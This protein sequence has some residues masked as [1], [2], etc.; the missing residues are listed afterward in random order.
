MVGTAGGGGGGGGGVGE[1]GEGGVYILNI[2]VVHAG[3]SPQM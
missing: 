1:G 2:H 3:S